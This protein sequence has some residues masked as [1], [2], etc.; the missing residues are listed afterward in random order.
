[1]SLKNFTVTS[2]KYSK[3]SRQAFKFLRW[4]VLILKFYKDDFCW[5]ASSPAA[6]WGAW[7]GS[8][9]SAM[10]FSYKWSHIRP[11]SKFSVTWSRKCS[12]TQTSSCGG[13]FHLFILESCNLRTRSCITYQANL[14]AASKLE[15][16]NCENKIKP[17]MVL[18][19]CPNMK[20]NVAWKINNLQ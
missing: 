9:V 13:S 15:T 6:V 3:F 8:S 5:G 16:V 10:I 20:P 1:M 4:F 18:R 2:I 12:H 17:N 7:F 19:C 14:R 11:E